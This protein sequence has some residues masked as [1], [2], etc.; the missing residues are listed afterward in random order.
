MQSLLHRVIGEDIEV[1]TY[2]DENLGTM[3]IDPALVEQVIMNLV[4]N[5]R[6]AM[7][8]GGKLTIETFNTELSYEYG[9]THTDVTPGRYV[10]LAISDT[11]PESRKSL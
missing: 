8:Q 11:D 6:D 9:E 10:A 4:I 7:P 1:N 3:E 2:L 5:S